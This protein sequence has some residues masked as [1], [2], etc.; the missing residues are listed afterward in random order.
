MVKIDKIYNFDY[1]IITNSE[2]GS[3]MVQ[4]QKGVLGQVFTSR[5][6]A[7]LMANLLVPYLDYSSR[8]LDPCIGKNVFFEELS[9][10]K[11]GELVGIEL[12]KQL[13]D[14]KVKTFFDVPNRNLIIGDFFEM[15]IKE[16]FDIIIMNPPYIRQELL[17]SKEKILKNIENANKIPGKSNLYVYFLSKALKHLKKNGALIA[18]TYDSWL[19]TDYGRVLKG[20]ILDE[21][22]LE[23]LVHFRNGAF[24]KVNVGATILLIVNTKKQK[25]VEYY[26]YDSSEN[27]NDDGTLLEDKLNKIQFDDLS[28]PHKLS[29]NIIDFESGLFVPLSSISSMPLNR[30][31][32]SIVNK[33]FIFK[34]NKYPPYTLKVIKDISTIDKFRVD[35][36]KDYLLKLP[37][38]VSSAP[39]L[40][41][42]EGVKINVQKNKELHKD[43]FNKIISRKYWFNI[44]N[45]NSGNVIFNYYF[46]NNT[47]FLYN[48]NGYL[49]A[50]NFYNLYIAENLFA[51]FA[52][53]N[54]TITKFALFK[55][56][57]SQGKGLFKI[58]LAQ[59]KT[60]PIINYNIFDKSS[61][62]KLDE[63]GNRLSLSDRKSSAAIITDIDNILLITLNKNLEKK[64]TYT[65]LVE[66]L[67]KLKGERHG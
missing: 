65:Q 1:T 52:I 42:L 60:L 11:H 24:D 66:D 8:C 38:E 6:I 3:A 56:G 47:N 63:L 64:V 49:V 39:I 22:S 55:Y 7:K 15:P 5:K 16:K 45:K 29:S 28:Q 54:S 40:K 14:E 27:L 19:F 34:E 36:T 17:K 58:Q 59:F 37:S 41:Y 2:V 4:Y 61:Q 31:I 50:D 20:I 62:K 35:D 46:R 51:N 25:A 13:I 26:S 23:K 48:I 44:K 32:S 57:R 21:Y 12:D 53:L 10:H 18:I 67:L 33:Y 9:S 30:G 43:L